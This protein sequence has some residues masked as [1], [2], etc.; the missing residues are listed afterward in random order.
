MAKASLI[1]RCFAASSAWADR[2]GL[3]ALILSI[4]ALPLHAQ[5]LIRPGSELI[6]QDHLAEIGRTL[7]VPSLQ[8]TTR[9][10]RTEASC[11]ATC[12]AFTPRQPVVSLEWEN[13]TAG[14][15]PTPSRTGAD[16]AVRID[17][18]GTAEGFGAGDYATVRLSSIPAF[19]AE[20]LDPASPVPLAAG[21][22]LLNQV[23]G[24]N[25]VPRAAD[26]PV[27]LTPNA[28]MQ[29]LPDLDAAGSAAVA[30]DLQTGGLGQVRALGR[31]VVPLRGEPHQIVS[32]VGFQPGGTYRV[33]IVGEGDD[34]AETITEQI[35]RIPVCPADFVGPDQ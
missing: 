21:E 13:A 23:R 24:N 35:C 4:A 30:A 17:V 15:E 18:S 19:E 33:R 27:F 3:K 2:P 6:G 9:L 28:M 16:A 31:S 25:V 14:T 20:V 12:D 26:L 1:F 34:R 5:D 10:A 8:A 29:A 7:A 22:V 32:L 11:T